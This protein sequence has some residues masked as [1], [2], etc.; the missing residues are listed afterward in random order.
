MAKRKQR[1]MLL[2]TYLIFE[3]NRF[4][5]ATINYNSNK[6]KVKWFL[7]AISCTMNVEQFSK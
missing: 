5:C 3:Y 1:K 7:F 4:N 2:M 6:I